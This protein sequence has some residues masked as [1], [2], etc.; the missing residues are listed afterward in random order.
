MLVAGL[1]IVCASCGARADDAAGTAPRE[2]PAATAPD[3]A[4]ASA[5]TPDTEAMVESTTGDT[6]DA[7]A[8]STTDVMAPTTSGPLGG[9]TGLDPLPGQADAASDPMVA[10]EAVRFAYEHW[11][12]LDLDPEVRSLVVEDGETTATGVLERLEELRS[13]IEFGRFHVQ[14][15]AF[16]DAEHATVTYRI[17]WQDGP[18]P[19]FPNEMTGSA[20]FQN[21]TWRITSRTLCVLAFGVGTDCAGE[22]PNPTPPA[23]LRIEAVPEGLSWTGRDDSRDVVASDGT[24]GIWAGGGAAEQ[25]Y[26]QVAVQVLVGISRVDPADLDALLA[27]GRYAGPESTPIDVAGARG[28]SV[29][30]EGHVYVVVIRPD[31]TVVRADAEGLTVDEV[32][33]AVISAVPAPAPDPVAG[34]D[35]MPVATMDP[36]DIAPA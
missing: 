2:P 20:V 28:R 9:V 12:L 30:S 15:V 36:T 31:D 26:L 14:T 35:G 13:I 3:T 27:Q 32:V 16:G 21:G 24:G 22:G 34:S 10:E 5:M 8:A 25:R 17:T 7:P 33:A 11:L 19:I 23:A 18:S 6:T 1:A 29:S 4:A